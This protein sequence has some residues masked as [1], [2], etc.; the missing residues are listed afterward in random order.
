VAPT[1]DDVRAARERIA[2]HIHPTPLMRH[3]VLEA[4]TG[5]ELWV[6]HENHNP[7][8]AFKGR[9]RFNL[10]ASPTP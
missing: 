2:P 6:K 9:G 4:E 1:L 8:G 5:L 3:P 7:T 10:V